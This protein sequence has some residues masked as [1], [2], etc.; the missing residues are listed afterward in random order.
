MKKKGHKNP[1]PGEL[2]K[3]AAF[4]SWAVIE[5]IKRLRIKG[6]NVTLKRGNNQLYLIRRLTRDRPDIAQPNSK[7]RRCWAGQNNGFN[8]MW[9]YEICVKKLG[10]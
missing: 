4:S 3:E 6:D 10:F 1:I 7:R 8:N 2:A 9:H 5:N